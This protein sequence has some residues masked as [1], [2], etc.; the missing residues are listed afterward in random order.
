MGSGAGL[1]IRESNAVRCVWVVD[2]AVGF[3]VAPVVEEDAAAG[4]SVLSPVVDAA[5]LVG[6]G[7]G[8]VV[9]FGLELQ[10]QSVFFFLYFLLYFSLVFLG[11]NIEK[12][13]IYPVVESLRRHVCE[14]DRL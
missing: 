3:G 11:G 6:G 2:D 9:A 4:D 8:N 14:L 12:R 1:E 5:F 13:D 10:N 7:A